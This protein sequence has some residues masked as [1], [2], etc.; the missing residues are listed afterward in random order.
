[1]ALVLV[2]KVGSKMF[3]HCKCKNMMDLVRKELLM[4]PQFNLHFASKGPCV[5]I[6]AGE[7]SFNL[8]LQC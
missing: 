1:M 5:K 2:H 4:G 6:S 7:Q 3:F 8:Y